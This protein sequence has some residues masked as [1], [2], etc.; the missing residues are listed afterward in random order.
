M[1]CYSGTKISRDTPRIIQSNRNW[2][3]KATL[4]LRSTPFIKIYS[5]AS[6]AHYHQSTISRT[7][8]E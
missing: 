2:R 5:T 8:L 1:G 7:K 6:R 4:I 3:M